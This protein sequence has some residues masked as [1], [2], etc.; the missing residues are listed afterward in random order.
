MK[1]TIYLLSILFFCF[2]I[3]TSVF[4]QSSSTNLWTITSNENLNGIPKVRRNSYPQSA[5]YYQLNLNE[6]KN[7][8]QNAP[9]REQLVGPSNLIIPFPNAYGQLEKYRVMESSCMEPGLEAKFPTIK[10]YAAQG[11]DDPTSFMRFS[12]T[13]FGLHTIAFSGN[14][15]TNY[16]DPYTTDL[17]NYIVY[18]RASLGVPAQ[19]FECLTDENISLPSL[20]ETQRITG[21]NQTMETNDRKL[22]TFRLAQSCTGEYGAIFMGTGTVAQQKSNVQAQMTITINRVNAVYE[23]DLA[24]HLNFV[25]NNDL[26]IYL[27]ANSDPWNNE[28]NTKTA[29]TID[30]VIGVNNYDIGHNFNTT[31]GGNAGC[32]SCVCLSTSQN[33]THKGRGYTGSTNPTGDPFDIDYVAHEMGHQFGGYHTMNT[34]S[35]SGS[36]TT[37]VEPASGSTVMGYAGICPTNVQNNSDDDFQ[38]VNVRDISLNIQ[39]G[40]STCGAITNIANQA[41]TANAGLDYTIPKSTAFILEGTASDP[42]GNAS[43]TYSWGENDPAQSPG[44]GAPQPT[45]ATGPMYR[46]LPLKSSPNRW[47][48]DI[49]S[50]IAGNLTP[51]WEVTP[52]VA[53]TL[54]FSFLVRD[55]SPMGGQTASDLMRVTVASSGPFVI[56]S[57]STATTWTGGST[58]TITWNVAS[59]TAAPVSCANVNVFLSI[60]GGYTYPYTIATN[61]PNN[62]TANITVPNISTTTARFMV[63]GAGNI[64]YDINNANITINSAG[65]VPPTA[66]ITAAATVCEGASVALTDAS[67]GSPTAWAWSTNAG[68]GATFSNTT[69]Q[70]PTV[71]FSVWG[72]Y[73]I[74]LVASNANGSSTYEKVITVNAKPVLTSTSNVDLCTGA[75]ANFNQTADV[76]STFS[77]LTTANANVTGE[78]TTTVNSATINN[79]LTNTTTSIQAVVYTVTPKAI[80]GACIGNPGTVT[81]NVIP[82]PTVTSANTASVCSGSAAAINLTGSV[83][84]SFSWIAT[85]NANVTGENTTT[86]TTSTITNTLTLSV[87]TAQTVL[88]T[89]TPTSTSGSCVGTAQTLSVTVNPLPTVTASSVPASGTICSGGSV[90]LTGGGASTYTWTGGVTNGAAFP[91]TVTTTY[92]V[93]GTAASGCSNTATKTITV[94]AGPTVT[95]SSNPASGTVCTGANVILSGSGAT[96]YT[97][98][99]GVVNGVAFTPATGTTVYTVTGTDVNGC[100]GTASVSITATAPPTVTS[101][102]TTNICS[103]NALAFTLTASAPSTFTWIAAN[104][105]NVTGESLTTQ[106]T[107]T[108]TNSLSSSSAVVENILYTITPTAGTCTGTPQTLTVTVNPLPVVTANSNPLSGTVCSGSSITLTGAGATSYTWNNSVT[109]GVAFVPSSAGPY[110]VTG[111]DVNGC[112]NTATLTVTINPLPTV[113][114]GSPIVCAGNSTTLTGAG[115]STYTWNNGVT[116]GVSFVPSASG[117]YIVTGT[118]VNGCSNTA[119]VTVT[120]YS[121]PTVSANS[122]SVC[123]GNSVTLT[124]TGASTYTWDNGVTDGVSFVPSVSGSY[125]VTGTGVNGCSNTATVTVTVYS[126]P[127]VAAISNPI[128]ATVC[129]GSSITLTGTGASTYSWDNGVVDGISFIPVNS[130]VYTVTGTDVNGCI[131]A[132][133]INVTVTAN[134]QVVASSS[135][136]G[137]V[138]EGTAVTLN[139]NNSANYTWLPAAGLS[140]TTGAS[141]TANPTA[142]TTYTVTGTIAGCISTTDIVTVSVNPLPAVPTVTQNGATLTSDATSGIQWYYNGVAMP[143]ETNPTITPAQN[144]DYSVIVTDINGCSSTSQ[145]FT[146]AN[147]GIDN[148]A[149]TT[150]N[151]LIVPNPNNGVFTTKFNKT[152]SEHAVLVIKDII[153]QVIMESQLSETSTQIDMRMFSK[154]VY[155]ATI[156]AGQYHHTV[157]FVVQ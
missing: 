111:T 151:M 113:S 108:I 23:R 21:Q 33:G 84:S 13:Q 17:N 56:T 72:T 26:I 141:V 115:A 39:S 146:V 14:H 140:S 125:I 114:A 118:D 156:N 9:V 90:T 32:L 85:N 82:L 5:L 57:Q 94:T 71:N 51:T 46:N 105:A 116:D 45:Y 143:G 101:A 8:L 58:Q 127:N 117:S 86:Q 48:P 37:E 24:V 95:A 154:G 19:K 28:W 25:A 65:A 148:P 18:D 63:R 60:D 55:N 78:S 99:G 68:A 126:L 1:K 75:I 139:G 2:A 119:T 104:N 145:I 144:G 34:C 137:T 110:I 157:K 29:Q 62:G 53:R 27:S 136:N 149:N 109:D 20:N 130:T 121:L 96:S 107:S 66:K 89:I 69:A 10:T 131:N 91:A 79:L 61:L 81:V 4:A 103:G 134:S 59:T 49:A 147:I 100:S 3:N 76:P 92:T 30:N 47:M 128:S 80:T 36:G 97:W 73:T 102:A 135:A 112:V 93:T 77:W 38:Y 155:F 123:A 52:S 98:T 153:G 15:S 88:Y 54:N 138:C 74:T 133:T 40:N 87:G 129:S 31:G 83:P 42:D 43:L 12:V 106:S 11:I 152:T 150:N 122:P 41:P 142:T 120:V 22:R 64:F 16:I 44:N 132:A 70:N 35:R 50:V 7:L 6:L 67:T 124:G